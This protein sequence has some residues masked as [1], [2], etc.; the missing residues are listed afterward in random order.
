MLAHSLAVEV[1]EVA[2]KTVEAHGELVEFGRAHLGAARAQAGL[3]TQGI[4]QGGQ[5]LGVDAYRETPAIGDRRFNCGLAAA[6]G[7]P[8]GWAQVG[9]GHGKRSQG[10]RLC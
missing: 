2:E 9:V 4:G 1:V 10:W 7:C 6:V 5:H 3:V 8:A